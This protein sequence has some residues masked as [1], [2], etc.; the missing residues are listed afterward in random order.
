MIG[1][2]KTEILANTSLFPLPV[3]PAG[4]APPK[5]A[6]VRQKEKIP[7]HINRHIPNRFFG[8]AWRIQIGIRQYA[9]IK[10]IENPKYILTVLKVPHPN[11]ALGIL[12]A[13]PD[14]GIGFRGIVVHDLEK[15]TAVEKKQIGICC[16]PKVAPSVFKYLIHVLLCQAFAPIEKSFSPNYFCFGFL[17]VQHADPS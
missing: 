17:C 14:M 11:S 13:H 2:S 5:I 7:P 15:L 6:V 9:A 10:L 4:R 3:L 12:T 1:K 16:D 8:Q